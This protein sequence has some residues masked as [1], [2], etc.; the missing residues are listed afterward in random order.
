MT[1]PAILFTFNGRITRSEFWL[2]G[3]L[4]MLPIGVLN[5][6]LMYGTDSD[7]AHTFAFVIVLI[8]LW[9]CAALYIKRLHD[10]DRSGWFLLMILI[11]F[12]NIIFGIW[13]I[14]VT[15][16]MR[17][18]VGSNRFGDDPFLT[19]KKSISD[20]AV[21]TWCVIAGAILFPILDILTKGGVPG[22]GG[23]KGGL[24]G[25]VIGSV[26]GFIINLVRKKL[27]FTQ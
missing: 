6:V 15:W 21:M 18:T 14:A 5:N 22:A 1:I 27:P 16:F 26:V 13:L 17:G 25:G 9:P 24:I 10:H 12:A 11:P 8:S 4:I 19:L 2:K 20:K 3:V 7:G 23:I